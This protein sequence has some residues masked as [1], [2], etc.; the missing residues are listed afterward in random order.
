MIKV[1]DNRCPLCGG[2][3][4]YYDCVKR[5]LKSKGGIKKHILIYRYKCV[6]CSSVHREIPDNVI[7]YKHYESDIIKGVI[8][9]RIT[10]WTEGF[11]DYP[12]EL[13]MQ[14]WIHTRK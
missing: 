4:K 13:T 12:C 1:N 3:L 7:P 2:Q 8:D 6:Q 11:E 5:I 10:S 14:R 9:R